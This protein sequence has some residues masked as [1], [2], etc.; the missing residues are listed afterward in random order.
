MSETT[1]GSNANALAEREASRISAAIRFIVGSVGLFRWNGQRGRSDQYMRQ[2]PALP[3]VR[4]RIPR[5]Y[6]I[7]R[8][9]AFW[10]G[11]CGLADSRVDGGLD[12]DSKVRWMSL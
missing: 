3:R 8:P 10:C 12:H 7:A 11:G 1:K 5:E 9:G 2:E 4:G 6:G